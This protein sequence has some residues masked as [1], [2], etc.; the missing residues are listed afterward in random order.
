MRTAIVISILFSFLTMLTCT[1]P[2][3]QETSKAMIENNDRAAYAIVIHGGAGTI[4]KSAMTAEQEAGYLQALNDALDIGENAL[5]AGGTSLEAVEKTLVFLENNPLF[6][7][8]KGAVFTHT[9]TN[10]LD[11]SVMEGATLRAGAV[12]GVSI[13]KNPIRAAIAVMQK[14][15]HVMLSG[16]G[17]DQF[18]IEQG[19]DTV[20]NSY[21]HTDN[22]WESLQKIKARED[23]K[24]GMLLE[25]TDSKY[26][27]VGCVAL[28][29]NGNLCAGTSTGGMT[30]KRWGRV[31]DSPI[32]GAG[33]YADNNTCGVSCTGHGEYFIRLAV[34]HDV[35]ARMAYLKEGVAQAADFVVNKKLKEMGG[36]GGLIAL[37]AKGNVAMPFNSEGMYRGFAKPGQ[38]I[39]KIYK[40]Q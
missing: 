9:G 39:V 13:V 4:L 33:T 18:A 22:R 37:D 30:N 16:A 23:N 8:G 17:A 26:G 6:N 12:A 10:E 31:G 40:G 20:P 35:S 21:F 24:S 34:A 1:S 27:T 29:K 38:R 3:N 14:S 28:D 25:H 7:A 5:K 36:E 32:I 11:A 2:S 19:L 15:P